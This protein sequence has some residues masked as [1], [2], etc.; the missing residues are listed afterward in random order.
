MRWLWVMALAG[1]GAGAW[2]EGIGEVLLRSQQLRLDAHTEVAEQDAAAQRIRASFDT[3]VKA[4]AAVAA[5][6]HEG[7]ALPAVQLRVVSGAPLAETLQ[8]RVIVVDVSL[9]A[10][11]EST[12]LFVLAHEWGHTAMRHWPQMTNLYQ[13]HIPGEVIQSHTDAIA[14]LLGYDASALAHRQE[15]EADAFALGVLRT[16]GLPAQAAYD[17]LVQQGFQPD[18]PTHPGTKRRLAA[19]RQVASKAP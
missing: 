8:G 12:R 6:E 18:T 14:A 15:M 10:A 7:S 11:P 5:G 1:A 9:A 3:V 4:A 2:G 13:S 19:L 17:A 16:L